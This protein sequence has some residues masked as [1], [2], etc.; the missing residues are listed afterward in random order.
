MPSPSAAKGT[1]DPGSAR[2]GA[3]TTPERDVA[4]LPGDIDSTLP[5]FHIRALKLAELFAK[6][7]DAPIALVDLGGRE[8]PVVVADDQDVAERV[9]ASWRPPAGDNGAR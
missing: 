7:V 3:A 9:A 6:T 4:D 1:T 2:T 8:C 5:A